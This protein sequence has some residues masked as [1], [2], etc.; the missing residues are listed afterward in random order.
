MKMRADDIRDWQI[1]WENYKADISIIAV[2]YQPNNGRE[3]CGERNPL[4]HI[5]DQIVQKTTFRKITLRKIRRQA[6]EVVLAG[7]YPVKCP[8]CG[9][10]TGG[11]QVQACPSCRRRLPFINGPRCFRCGKPVNSGEIEYCMD[12][13]KESHYFTQG[14]SLWSY[15][16]SVKQAVYR[17]KYKNQRCYGAYFG[18]EIIRQYY[19]QIRAWNADAIIPVPIHKNRY[20]QRGY[21][22]AELIAQ[23]ISPY[24]RVPVETNLVERIK[25][26]KPQ[27]E[28]NDKERQKN[29]KNAFKINENS[30][31]LKKVIIVDDIYTT[32]ATVDV[33]AELLLHG[34]ISDIYVIT[35]CI[36][37]GY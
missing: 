26:T 25:N 36:G 29:L 12:C 37:R 14:I 21:N 4:N 31:K 34:G 13:T 22:Q 35:L 33:I 20:R 16:Q 19:N 7:L 18:K 5:H 28:L 11:V 32:G 9:K 24:I 15:D 6:R 1:V 17:F 27:K 23:S 8:F 2:I 10:R 30:V 3:L